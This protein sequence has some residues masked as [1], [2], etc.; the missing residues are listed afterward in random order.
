[1]PEGTVPS[2]VRENC[3]SDL[4]MSD[5]DDVADHDYVQPSNISSNNDEPPLPSKKRR[6]RHRATSLWQPRVPRLPDPE[7]SDKAARNLPC[8]SRVS[9]MTRMPQEVTTSSVVPVL[10]DSTHHGQVKKQY[11]L[12][13][14]TDFM[15]SLKL[16]HTAVWEHR[17]Y[18]AFRLLLCV[19]TQAFPHLSLELLWK[20]MDVITR[21]VP[22]LSVDDRKKF[23][24]ILHGMQ[25]KTPLYHDIL[26]QDL[27]GATDRDA[28]ELLQMIEDIQNQRQPPAQGIETRM[29]IHSKAVS[30]G[31]VHYYCQKSSLL[32]ATSSSQPLDD[33][34]HVSHPLSVLQAS[35]HWQLSE[36]SIGLI[37]LQRAFMRH[38]SLL[39]KKDRKRVKGISL[40]SLS[41]TTSQ[42]KKAVQHTQ[43]RAQNTS[44]VAAVTISQDLDQETQREG[45]HDFTECEENLTQ[46]SPSKDSANH[47]I[48]NEETGLSPRSLRNI[49]DASSENFLTSTQTRDE[50]CRDQKKLVENP[51][52]NGTSIICQET[53]NKFASSSGATKT[54][55][56]HCSQSKIKKCKS[57]PSVT[58]KRKYFGDHTESNDRGDGKQDSTEKRRILKVCL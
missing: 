27:P 35:G 32:N 40:R 53:S 54:K 26:S 18:D 9:A 28:D 31:Q 7:S 56:G 30:D 57:L 22:S 15:W 24:S 16:L 21:N 52:L 36:E 47:Y 13:E 58:S 41:K 10:S 49:F 44:E 20:I 11:N 34:Q 3:G 33:E 14:K 25:L 42:K 8:G 12:K 50:R 6:K 29:C 45:L 39:A 1:M 4:F 48:L 55:D 5:D 37:D 38:F 2:T 17:W 46:L 43:E 23:R 19:V 51:E